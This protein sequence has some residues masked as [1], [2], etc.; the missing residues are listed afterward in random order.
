MSIDLS[1]FH[2]TFF[3]E[4][5]E[6]LA[7][8]ETGLLNLS[9]GEVETEAVNTLF[10]VAHSIKGGSAM[11]GFSAIASLTHVMETLLDHVRAGRAG[12][13]D[14]SWTHCSRPSIV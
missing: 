7:T 4:S 2:Q 5:L 13:I 12:S 3:E 11:F 6:G 1:Q 14:C 10:R 9:P 8:M